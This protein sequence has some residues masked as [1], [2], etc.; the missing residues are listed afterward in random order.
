M[1]TTNRVRVK[2]DAGYI[3]GKGTA[4]KS[5]TVQLVQIID[6]FH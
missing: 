4:Q 3:P 6:T 1:N 2:A 5:K